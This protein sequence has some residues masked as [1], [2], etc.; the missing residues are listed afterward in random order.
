M[1]QR[2]QQGSSQ[3]QSASQRL[4]Q[5]G[6]H[7]NIGSRN[8]TP[9]ASPVT[10]QPPVGM[11][12][13]FFSNIRALDHPVLRPKFSPISNAKK[14]VFSPNPRPKIPNLTKKKLFFFRFS[15]FISYYINIEHIVTYLQFHRIIEYNHT[16]FCLSLFSL[17]T[18]VS[19]I[20]GIILAME[21]SYI[22]MMSNFP[23][24]V[25]TQIIFPIPWATA[26][27]PKRSVRALNYMNLGI[28]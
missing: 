20:I 28:A 7:T 8:N 23:I 5:L 26:P 9:T 15:I 18:M 1:S 25:K 17:Y 11:L 27:F 21:R 6:I 14:Y 12:S 3:S 16:C 13:N 24:L 22:R 4:K 2:L 19:L 10:T